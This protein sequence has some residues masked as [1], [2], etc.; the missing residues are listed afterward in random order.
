M[1]EEGDPLRPST[2]LDSHLVQCIPLR[3]SSGPFR[4]PSTDPG[5]LLGLL[6]AEQLLQLVLLASLKTPPY[7]VGDPSEV[8]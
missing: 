6:W 1:A 8:P 4:A 5:R 7:R 3:G 2:S